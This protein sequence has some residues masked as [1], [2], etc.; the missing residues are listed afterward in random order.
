M[1]G[2]EFDVVVIGSGFGGAVAASTLTSAGQRVLLLERGPWRDT[3]PVRMAGIDERSPLPHGRFFYSHL[4]HQLGGLRLNVRGLFDIHPGR[5]MSIVCA[6][7]VGGGSHV[8][9]AMNTRPAR[10]D[11]WDGHVP[12]ITSSRM[13]QHY[14]WMIT[15]MGAEVLS[16][17]QTTN[18][19][20]DAYA[21]SPHFTAELE[22]PAVSVK[23]SAAEVGENNSFLGSTDGSKATLDQILLLPAMAQGL[24]IRALHECRSLWRTPQG[25]RLMV[26]DHRQNRL[27]PLLANKVILAA[28][29]LNTLRLLFSSRALGGLTG[30][31]ALGLGFGG[32]GD[33]PA[34]WAL[35]QPEADLSTGL[36]CHG[37]FALR[38]DDGKPF[39]LPG[40]LPVDLTR[41]GL[42]G[43]DL[44]PMPAF[45]RR[46]LKRNAILVGMGADHANGVVEWHKGRLIVRYLQGNNPVLASIYRHFAEIARR[47]GRPVYVRQ[48]NALTVHPLGG[49]RLGSD[50]NNSVV[51]SQGEVH[52]NPGL[53]L[54]DASALPAAPGT[55]PSMTIA[56]WARH[57]SLNLCK[58]SENSFNKKP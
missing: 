56:A 57:L 58:D 55:P 15:A 4:L 36:P 20:G 6:S 9:S 39:T 47:S 3:R 45:I 23:R 34:Y 49:A 43:V 42:N 16:S 7:G 38:G 18:F 29:T 35:N 41:Y 28:G 54:A 48:R 14:Q 8:Y 40:S 1:N 46:R 30:M 11:Y 10:A 31:P 2:D 51:N 27:Y 32:N 44:I 25:Y 24:E 12:G 50:V 13:E 17:G 19:T 53:Y 37:R 5:D 22:Q 26:M 52:D 21:Q 33:V